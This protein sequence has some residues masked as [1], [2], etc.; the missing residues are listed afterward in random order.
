ML[1]PH[2]YGTESG[3]LVTV[4]GRCHVKL[5]EATT[6][7]VVAITTVVVVVVV[8]VVVVVVVV[9]ASTARTTTCKYKKNNIRYK[10]CK[11]LFGHSL[12]IYEPKTNEIN[13]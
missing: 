9:V 8:F 1:G 4:L 5:T 12:V 3:T 2:G 13:I 11:I 10:C 6:A 7:V